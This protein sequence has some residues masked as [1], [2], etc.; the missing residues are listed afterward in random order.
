M[1]GNTSASLKLSVCIFTYNHENFISET[2]ESAL[3]QVTDFEY[4]IVIGEDCSTDST[5]KI[6]R[7]YQQQHPGS[8]RALFNKRNLGMMENNSQT[9]LQCRGEYIALM[10]GD[11]YWIH[12]K[13]LQAQVDFLEANPSYSLCFH[14]AKILKIDGQWNHKSTCCGPENKRIVSFTD[15]ICD[16]HIPTSSLVFRRTALH[17]YPPRWFGSL[18]AP[19]RPLFLMLTANGPGYYFKEIWS[20]YRQHPNGTWTGQHYQSQWLTHLQIYQV[21]NRHYN[22]KYDKAFCKCEK[23]AAYTLAS[24]LMKENKVK[25]AFCFLRVYRRAG[26]GRLAIRPA[27]WYRI[28]AFM[29]IYLKS[30]LLHRI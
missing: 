24:R 21:L 28:I 25:R 29:L 16:V 11:D 9:L 3:N 20:V 23:R 2:I 13:K 27:K 12:N 1:P 5:G 22:H 10:D 8:I 14:D 15:V 6:V 4:E 30:R 17:D 7:Y 19:D 18:N 26:N